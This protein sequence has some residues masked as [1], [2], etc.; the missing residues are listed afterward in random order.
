MSADKGKIFTASSQQWRFIDPNRPAGMPP[1]TSARLI[2]KEKPRDNVKPPDSSYFYKEF[3]QLE[4]S[5]KNNSNQTNSKNDFNKFSV[6]SRLL[7]YRKD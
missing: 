7:K 4:D 1:L 2:E 5:Y 6:Q 3:K